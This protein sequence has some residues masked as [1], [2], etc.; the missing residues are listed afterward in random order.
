MTDIIES[1]SWDSVPELPA[2]GVTALG[3]TGGPA[4]WQ[5]QAL[6]NRFAALRDDALG[7]GGMLIGRAIFRV[8]T[9][10]EL[11]SLAPP[12]KKTT[13]LLEGYYAA[14]DGGGGMLVWMPT[15]TRAD[16]GGTVFVPNSNPLNGRWERGLTYAA[17]VKHF[18]AKGTNDPANEA[19]D[20]LA[21]AAAFN[22]AKVVLVPVGDFFVS[23]TITVGPG[24][25]LCGAGQDAT[26]IH[27][28]GTDAAIYLGAPGITTLAYNVE[29]KDLTVFC[30]NRATTIKGVQL[31][32]AVYFNLENVSCFGSGNPNASAPADRV[33]VGA[34]VY[35]SNNSIIGRISHV[36]C[37]LWAIGR[38]Y[39]TLPGSGS[40]W[41]AAIIDSGHGE[42]GNN[43]VGVQVG[44]PTVGWLSGAGLTMRDLTIQG[45]Y[46]RGIDIN[47]GDSTIV[48]SC[49][50]EGNAGNDL[51]I[52][53][54]VATPIM[55]RCTNCRMDSE[56]IGTTPYGTFPYVS[57]VWIKKGS[58][59]VID[60]NDMSI[61]SN[62]PLVRIEAASDGATVSRNR[63]NST[64]STLGRISDASGNTI[65]RDNFP[66]PPA[67]AAG[68]FSRLM[69]AA[70]GTQVVTGLGFRPMRVRFFAAV[71]SGA[72]DCDGTAGLGNGVTQ[73]CIST[74]TAGQKLSSGD[75]IRII[76]GTGNE[77]KA[78]LT[79]VSPDGFTVTWTKLGTPAAET[80]T[81][82]FEAWR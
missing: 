67:Y 70:S 14:G 22:V 20:T 72:S 12:A 7:N 30:T 9:V 71:D 15:S 43:M 74:D 39:L 2:T 52:G 28:S 32:N 63:L 33:L 75:A 53:D 49:Y 48:E 41:S 4:N 25:S 45:N 77:Q 58:F 73:R 79:A 46:T 11:R 10:A 3:G 38:Y 16:D 59:A 65:T 47:A 21:F 40:L 56:D 54:G 42:L 66:E 82:N 6:A 27:Y 5:A 44:D 31:D 69:T 23:A 50:F 78:S 36:S 61:S 55:V 8:E 76:R 81:I 60:M 17:S 37:R 18:G 13:I 68:S 51:V 57:K 62:I 19:T 64:A 35:V 29:C 80:A 26:R 1:P 24:R 34:G